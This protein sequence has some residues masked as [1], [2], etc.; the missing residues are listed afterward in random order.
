[1]RPDHRLREVAAH[2]LPDQDRPFQFQKPDEREEVVDELTP[3]PGAVVLPTWAL[4]RV[5]VAAN[6]AHPSYTHGYSTRDNDFYVA[7]DEISRDRDRFTA[8]MADHVL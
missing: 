5:A 7:W 1:M 3:V 8:W 2:R 4:T 6:G